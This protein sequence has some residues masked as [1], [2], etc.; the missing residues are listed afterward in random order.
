MSKYEQITQNTERLI[1]NNFT[2][3]QEFKYFDTEGFVQ[4]DLPYTIYYTNEKR[5]V[6][7]TGLPSDIG[8][9]RRIYKVNETDLFVTY[10]SISRAERES[11]PK[12]FKNIPTTNDYS[13]GEFRRYFCKKA[14]DASSQIFE[15]S[16]ESYDGQSSLYSYYEIIWKISG[17]KNTVRNQNLVQIRILQKRVPEISRYLSP[18]EYWRPQANS[19]DD[20]QKKLSFLKK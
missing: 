9:R 10:Q 14:N 12:A 17:N 3:F 2:S 13:V 19:L 1:G 16:Q 5:K 18:L 8:S 20:V 7:L 4:A 11:Y 6:Y 15:I